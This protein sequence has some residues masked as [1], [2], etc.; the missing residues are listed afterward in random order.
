M[1]RLKCS[2]SALMIAMVSAAFAQQPIKPNAIDDNRDQFGFGLKAGVNFANVYDE[3]GED[4]VADGKTGFFGGVFVKVPLGTVIGIQPEVN[5]SQKGF[6]ARGTFLGGS[7]NFERTTSY[8]DI[9]VLLQIK[10]HKCITLLA[11]P[12]FSYLLETKDSFNDG[13]ITLVQEEEITQDNYRKNILGAV[14]GVE[15]H[16]KGL[17]LTA[18]GG[19]DFTKTDAEGNSTTPRYKNQVFQLGL[20]YTFY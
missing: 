13:T 11:G 14:I 20:G 9:P 5:Y 7:Y 19:F 17:L 2:L 4:F 10:P 8:L 3:E 16:W 18:R 15:A 12:Q 1:K 6:T